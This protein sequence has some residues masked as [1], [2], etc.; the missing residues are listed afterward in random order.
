MVYYKPGIG[1]KEESDLRDAAVT[2]GRNIRRMRIKRGIS[3]KDLAEYVGLKKSTLS[4]YENARSIP[5]P[6]TIKKLAEVLGTSVEAIKCSSP[7]ILKSSGDIYMDG[8][9]PYFDN[10]TACVT[11]GAIPD[12]I[13]PL[14][15]EFGDPRGFLLKVNTDNFR[16]LGIHDGTVVLFGSQ[17]EPV[18]N[19]ILVL[20]IDNKGYFARIEAVGETNMKLSIYDDEEGSRTQL[21]PIETD[22]IRGIAV[23]YAA[24]L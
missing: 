15:G 2:I 14:V 8:R 22:I 21:V 19:K 7:R 13:F 12:A 9:I 4:N 10:V 23:M 20:C 18:Q 3:A 5:K 16:D 1:L 17:S 11:P 24:A 6:E